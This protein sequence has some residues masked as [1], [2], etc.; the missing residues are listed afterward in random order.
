MKSIFKRFDIYCLIL[1]IIAAWFSEHYEVFTLIEDQTLSI[2]QLL[3]T[4]NHDVKRFKDRNVVLVSLDDNFYKNINRKPFNRLELANIIQN[5]QKLGPK[6]IVVNLLMRYPTNTLDDKTLYNLLSDPAYSNV[7]LAS[8]I[9]FDE[10]QTSGKIIYPSSTVKPVNISTGYVNIMSPSAVVTFLSRLRIYPEIA[11]D[12]KYNDGWPLAIQAAIQYLNVK[13]KINKQ[14]LQLGTKIFQLDQNNDLYIDYSPVPSHGRFLNDYIGITAYEFLDQK[15]KK[16]KKNTNS[17]L[18]SEFN[19]LELSYWI[20]DKIVVIG[21]TSKDTRDWFDTPVGTM[22]G[23]E[24]VADTINTLIGDTPLSPASCPIE[25]CISVIMLS[26][27]LLSVTRFKTARYSFFA[28][29]TINVL[30]TVICSILY[31]YHGYI[32]TMTYN[33]LFGLIAFIGATL[34]YRAVDYKNKEMAKKELET[35]QAALEKAE[36]KYRSIFENAMEGIFQMDMDGNIISANPSALKILGYDHPEELQNI[37]FDR[38]NR[39]YVDRNDQKKLIHKLNKYNMVKGFETRVYRKDGGWL[40]VGLFVRSVMGK[41]DTVDFYEGSFLDITEVKKRFQAEREAEAA[42]AAMKS[43]TEILASMSHELRTPLNA[44]LGMANVLK[45]SNLTPEQK[46]YV[47]VFAM[48]GEHLLV[49]INDVLSLSKLEAGTIKLDLVPFDLKIF[50][51]TVQGIMSMQDQR[52]KE[53]ELIYNIQPQIP[54]QL[55]GDKIR[56]QQIITNLMD[57]AIKFTSKGSITLTVSTKPLDEFENNVL[58]IISDDTFDLYFFQVKD[59][60]IG[61]PVDKQKTIFDTFC[62]IK[63]HGKNIGAGLGL[64][65]CKR[66]VEYMGGKIIVNSEPEKGSTFSFVVPLR[67]QEDTLIE[68]KEPIKIKPLKILLVEDNPNNQMVFSIYLDDTDHHIE[69][70]SDGDEGVEEFKKNKYDIVFMDLQMPKV[71]GF[72]A[73]RMMRQWEK[74]NNQKE[75]PI[76]AISAQTFL[77]KHNKATDA[78]C[79]AY[80]EKPLKKEI[81][82]DTLEKYSS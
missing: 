24:I 11:M 15:N 48:A 38:E 10:K 41:D 73:T 4:S 53:V 43:R 63:H 77:N 37:L 33:Y 54:T 76:I 47:E 9:E 59:T 42:K 40:W 81:L 64:A 52:Q 7:I 69:I 60:G 57:N 80:L 71:D 13:P 6:L 58:P 20:K 65:I 12:S 51:Q 36:S 72:E 28:Y 34:C 18:R 30:F 82:F 5:V 68:K 31:T 3:R 39:L 45:E 46:K 22:Y 17:L 16:D 32:I 55:I 49:L 23:A 14:T 61:I 35:K 26:L 78:G 67:L 21:D 79:T 1:L 8:H 25:C 44:I 29:L 50:F 56:L 62:Q 74:D 66:L 70:T 75:T 2:R 27:I 19:H